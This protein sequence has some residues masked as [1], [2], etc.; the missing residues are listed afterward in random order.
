MNT[1]KMNPPEWPTDLQK[2]LDEYPR[3]TAS[4]D[5]NKRVLAALAAK[6][7]QQSK[8]ELFCD[9][10]DRIFERPIL[11]LFGTALFAILLAWG[12]A[13]LVSTFVFPNISEQANSI[14]SGQVNMQTQSLDA[15]T[16]RSGS[17][18][19]WD[20][21]IALQ[22][23]PMNITPPQQKNPTVN[24]NSTDKKETSCSPNENTLWG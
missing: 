19:A 7:A 10:L 22:M 16:L 11:K 1:K 12:G 5:F 21:D 13:N 2:A 24:S 18:Y 23:N 15:I 4:P 17:L 20:S 8:L 3:I 14:S 9:N 6:L